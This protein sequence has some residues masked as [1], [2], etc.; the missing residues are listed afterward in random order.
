MNKNGQ[1]NGQS[2]KNEIESRFNN[3]RHVA[4]DFNRAYYGMTFDEPI[5]LMAIPRKIAAVDKR[6]IAPK[7]EHEGGEAL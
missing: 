6:L 5:R 3:D 1:L 2:T 7:T 4:D